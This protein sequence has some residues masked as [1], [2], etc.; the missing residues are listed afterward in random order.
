MQLEWQLRRQAGVISR[1]QATD[2]G[3]S[4]YAVRRRVAMGRWEQLHPGVYL[5]A[6]HPYTNEVRLRAGVLACGPEAVAHGVAAAWWHGM[7]SELPDPVDVTVPRLRRPRPG[8]GVQIRRRDLPDRDVVE[9]RGVWLTEVPLTVLEAAVALGS[10][11]GGALLDRALQRRVRFAAVYRAHCRNLGR[12]GSARAA[13]LLA[14]AADRAGSHAERL[15]VQILREAG[16]T[17]WRLGFAV[18]EYDIDLAFPAQRVAIEVDG[19][20]WHVDVERFRQDRRRQNTLVNAGWTVLRFTWHD[21]SGD[22]RRV[23]AEIRAALGAAP[24]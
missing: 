21:V 19:W 8:S 18:A 1:Q 4:R 16:I 5:A 2:A 3:L 15:L 11:G 7:V 14:A 12:R 17:G 6:E 22:P 20:A 13:A 9:I 10:D 23:V 24:A